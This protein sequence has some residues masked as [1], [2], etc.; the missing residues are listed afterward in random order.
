MRDAL[1]Q[2]RGIENVRQYLG[3]KSLAS[4]GGYLPVRDEEASA[5]FGSTDEPIAIGVLPHEC[6]WGKASKDIG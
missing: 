4:A 1:H 2:K 3:H 6:Y 5:A